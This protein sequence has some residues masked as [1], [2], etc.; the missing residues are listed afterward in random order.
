MCIMEKVTLRHIYERTRYLLT[1]PNVEWSLI[2]DEH[3]E[4]KGLLKS[5][6]LPIAV[7]SSLPIFLFG[8]FH[9]SMM[10]TVGYGLINLPASLIG[11]W[12]A[13]LITREFLSNKLPNAD[14]TALSLIVYSGTIF[15][16]FHSLGIALG[17][18]FFGQLCT[19]VSFI[20]I[21]T[22]YIGIRQIKELP[23]G[24]QTNLLVIA[25]LSIICIP[26]IIAQI[27]TIIFGISAFNI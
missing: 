11:I 27:L 24:Q 17:N 18:G 14:N 3:H 15:V 23:N 5:Y 13:Y 2:M 22:L 25:A 6:L 16:V 9:Y 21:R 8:F 19:L 20:F 10:Q 26:V 7:I 4:P 12:V 1:K